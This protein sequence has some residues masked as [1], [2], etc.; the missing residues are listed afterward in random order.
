MVSANGRVIY[1][2]DEGRVIE[3]GTHQELLL[4]DGLYAQSWDEKLQDTGIAQSAADAA[5]LNTL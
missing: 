4:M 2:M 3:S 1:V 5:I